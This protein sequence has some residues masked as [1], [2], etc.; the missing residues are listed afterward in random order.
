MSAPAFSVAPL[1]LEQVRQL[2][3]ERLTADF[4][5]EECKPLSRIEQA[6]RTGKYRSFGAAADGETL[7][8]AFFVT[9]EGGLWLLDYLAVREDLRGSGLG[10][11]FLRALQETAL[12][13]DGRVLLETEDPDWAQDAAEREHCLRRLRFYLRS[14]MTDTGVRAAVWGAE[15]RVLR[16]ACGP[17]ATADEAAEWYR[18]LYREILPPPLYRFKVR[19]WTEKPY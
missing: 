12:P 11:A 13:A 16:F 1:S 17:A 19:V 6:M 7:A 18:Q 15:Y 8:Y 5:P 14:G 3:R 2:Y 10:S 9:L 4:R